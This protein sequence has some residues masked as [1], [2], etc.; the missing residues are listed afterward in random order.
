MDA[1]TEQAKRNYGLVPPET[2]ATMSGLELLKGLAEG[3]LPGAPIM[4]LIGFHLTE[5]ENGRAVFE[6]T[7]A[8]RHYNP[9]GTVHGGYA[10]TLLDSCMGC[11]VHSTLPKGVGYI[12]LEFKVSLVRP[13]TADTG[14]VRAE[15][16]VINGG[17]R[18]ATAEGR[19][20]DAAGRLLAH[21]TTTCLVF[22]VAGKPEARQ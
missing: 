2:A 13:I 1:P 12:T 15:G 20:T 22:E 3:R 16:K 5:V 10:A 19:L 8:F 7:P 18:V 21:A 11:A 17:R 9:L 6:G 4:E 14:R